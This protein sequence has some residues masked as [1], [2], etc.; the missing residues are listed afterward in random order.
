M[1]TNSQEVIDRVHYSLRKIEDTEQIRQLYVNNV[2]AESSPALQEGVTAMLNIEQR[3]RQEGTDPVKGGLPPFGQW[4]P[5]AWLKAG[6]I[7]L[8]AT[9]AAAIHGDP[10]LMN[11]AYGMQQWW[12]IQIAGQV[13]EAAYGEQAN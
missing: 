3:R 9:E 8:G 7:V 2:F 6:V 11:F 4:P 1:Q 10:Q 12:F 5:A 13:T